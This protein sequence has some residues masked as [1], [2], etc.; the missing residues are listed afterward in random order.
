MWFT[1]GELSAVPV[2]PRNF[3][4]NSPADV[5]TFEVRMLEFCGFR[6]AARC[7]RWGITCGIGDCEGGADPFATVVLVIRGD[8][9]DP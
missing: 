4:R 5:S 3:A 9:P 8:A 7:G 2:C 6:G 1:G